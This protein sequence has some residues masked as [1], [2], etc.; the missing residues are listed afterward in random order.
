[1]KVIVFQIRIQV[2]TSIL[3]YLF[4]KMAATDVCF[5]QKHDE[6]YLSVYYGVIKLIIWIGR[7]KNIY[8]Y[9]TT[10]LYIRIMN[11]TVKIPCVYVTH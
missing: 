11:V 10:N 6:M 5:Q 4:I 2:P 9:M 1:M 3:G 8:V 7:L